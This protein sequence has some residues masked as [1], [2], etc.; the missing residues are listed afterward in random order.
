MRFVEIG[1]DV[2]DLTASLRGL[3]VL[4]EYKGEEERKRE[5]N[6]HL[7]RRR[8]SSLNAKGREGTTIAPPPQPGWRWMEGAEADRERMVYG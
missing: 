6:F 1:P 5:R 4:G 8:F 2:T 7:G 3:L